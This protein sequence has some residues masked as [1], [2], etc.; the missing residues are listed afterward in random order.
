MWLKRKS[1]LLLWRHFLNNT[2]K[3]L[4]YKEER[5]DLA[6]YIWMELNAKSMSNKLTDKKEA[7]ALIRE[8][9]NKY[10]SITNE[11]IID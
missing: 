11:I 7:V 9:I 1:K 10:L 3:N 4:N 6:N 2:N 5:Q 8:G